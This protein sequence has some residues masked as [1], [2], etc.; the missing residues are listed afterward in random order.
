MKIQVKFALV[1]TDYKPPVGND[2]FM[3]MAK[4]GSPI[5][6]IIVGGIV[7]GFSYWTSDKQCI[8]SREKPTETPNIKVDETGKA[9]RVSHF[10]VVPVFDCNTETV[11]L[12][13]ITQRGLQDQLMEIFQGNDYDLGDLT[14]PM[15]IKISAT[16]EKL[17]TKYTLMPVPSNIQ[18]LVDL[19]EASDL[20]DMDVDD[21]V[22]S[23]PKS[24]SNPTS[25]VA[26]P[27]PTMT[28]DVA[29]DMM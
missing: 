27:T 22:F 6:F 28:T 9:D 24:T 16:G 4:A 29:S 25:A 10:W 26:L 15:A 14:N 11:K 21:I 18:G 2:I 7:T 3:K 20:V 13:E 23:T 17:T 8:R 5:K 19:L 1:P 12:L